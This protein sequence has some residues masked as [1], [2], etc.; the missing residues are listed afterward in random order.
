MRFSL[1]LSMSQL[2]VMLAPITTSAAPAA[3]LALVFVVEVEPPVR[4][5]GDEPPVLCAGLPGV[6]R[7]KR[8]RT[9]W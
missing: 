1:P 8:A 2:S 5:G 3:A 7:E 6:G 4:A 9:R